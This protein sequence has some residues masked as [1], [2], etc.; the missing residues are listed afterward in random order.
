MEKYYDTAISLPIHPKLNKNHQKLIC[1]YLKIFFDAKN[2]LP[3]I[4]L[5]CA[6]SHGGDKSIFKNNRTIF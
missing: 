3:I 4:L 5:E 6:N 2:K 1:K